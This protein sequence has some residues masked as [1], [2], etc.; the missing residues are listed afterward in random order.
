MDIDFS[1]QQLIQYSRQI[2]LPQIDIS[3]QQKLMR[4]KVLVLGAG[5]LGCPTLMY[6]ASS[7]VGEIT[8]VDPD[9]VEL[10]NL[11]RQLLFKE[12]DIGHSKAQIAAQQVRQINSQCR[13]A[14]VDNIPDDVTLSKLIEHADVVIEGTDNFEA[15]YRHNRACLEASTPLISGAVIRF[16]G[17]VTCFDFRHGQTP[18]YAC[19]YAEA[20]DESLNCSENGVLP[21]V[22][23][24]IAS[25]MV[26]ECVKLITEIGESLQGRLLLLDAMSM[27]WR[28][29]AL[30]QDEHCTVCGPTRASQVSAK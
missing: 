16:E 13:V 24:M 25:T 17:Q 8:I 11:H 18:C 21:S 20:S 6:L 3:G 1:D 23:A 30:K 29:I 4:A 12:Q 7:G 10:S 2:M 22:V 15:R 28:C 9:V 27:E 14:V 5:G 26:T 19:L